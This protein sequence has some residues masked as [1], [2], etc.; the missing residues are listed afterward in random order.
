[1]TTFQKQVAA[2]L[3]ELLGYSKHFAESAIQQNWDTV[4]NTWSAERAASQIDDA[5]IITTFSQMS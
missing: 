4:T 1:M 5:V 2:V 3:V